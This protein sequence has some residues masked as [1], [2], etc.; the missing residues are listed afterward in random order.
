MILCL[1]SP[2]F[3][4]ELCE[5]LLRLRQQHPTG[6]LPAPRA[7]GRFRP[8][9]RPGAELGSSAPSNPF[10]SLLIQMI[11]KFTKLAWNLTGARSFFRKMIFPD[12]PP[13]PR[14]V[15][16]HVNLVEGTRG[17]HILEHLESLCCNLFV[18]VLVFQNS[19][20]KSTLVPTARGFHPQSGVS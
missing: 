5:L 4:Q 2:D 7:T 15:R 8:R 19:W 13:P 1:G 18:E 3:S 10:N 12:P 11:P 9:K 14:N 16:F 6:P 17:S 20:P